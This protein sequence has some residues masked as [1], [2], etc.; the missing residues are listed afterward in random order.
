MDKSAETILEELGTTAS[1]ASKDLNAYAIDA[2]L[3]S[4]NSQRLIAKYPNQWIAVYQGDVRATADTLEALLDELKKRSIP[5]D[6]AI[7]RYIEDNPR[8]MI[9]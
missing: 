7:V 2:R 6:K 5:A 9:L 1:Q 4:S 8:I 3:L